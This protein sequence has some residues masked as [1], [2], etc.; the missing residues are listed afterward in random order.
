MIKPGF[1]KPKR[2]KI[3]FFD[4]VL[5]TSEVRSSS[6]MAKQD[7]RLFI[8]LHCE[9]LHRERPNMKMHK[10]QVP[11]CVFFQGNLVTGFCSIFIFLHYKKTQWFDGQVLCQKYF[12]RLHLQK[13]AIHCQCC[14]GIRL[15]LMHQS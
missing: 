6:I 7:G 4:Y 13:E 14:A 1:L 9:K 8:R 3:I 10:G 12:T 11:S 5:H 15:P 2:T